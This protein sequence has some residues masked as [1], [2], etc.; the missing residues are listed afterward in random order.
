MSGSSVYTDQTRSL[1]GADS[2]GPDVVS[3]PPL[4][5]DRYALNAPIGSG[6][7]GVVW[8]ARDLRTGQAVAIKMLRP[9][10][11]DTPGAR[12][13]FHREVTNA[14][15]LDHPNIVRI[16]GHGQTANGSLYLV[17][18]RLSG[19][20]LSAHLARGAPLALTRGFHIVAQVL[21]AIGAAHRL[22]IVH[23]DLK[24]GNIILVDAADGREIVKICDF[25]LAKVIDPNASDDAEAS[26]A[27]LRSSE[28]ITT[29][30]G[31]LC[32]TPEFMAPEQ[33]R[34]EPL[35]GRAD[36]YSIAV[37]L[38][39]VV[40]G[41]LPFKGRTPFA[42]VSQHLGAAPPRPST[43]RPAAGITPALEN[44]IL[45][46]LAKDRRERPSSAEVFR[47]DLLQIEADLQRDERRRAERRPG[48][49]DASTLTA[50]PL[51]RGS[52][53]RGKSLLLGAAAV[54]AGAAAV[55]AVRSDGGSK[56][57]ASPRGPV[58]VEPQRDRATTRLVV[59]AREPVVPAVP[60][61]IIRPAP[62][63]MP[64]PMPT[65]TPTPTPT[66]QRKGRAT[67]PAASAPLPAAPTVA[68]PEAPAPTPPPLGGDTGVALRRAQD[69]MAEGQIARAC[70]LVEEAARIAPEAAPLHGFLGRCYL[71]IGRVE[72]GRASY[73]RYLE[74]APAAPDAPF[75][76][77]IVAGRR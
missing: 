1:A 5:D 3:A 56:A 15:A 74:L 6:S 20:T 55:V 34:G 39:Q 27:P 53:L 18:E 43:I 65:S 17:M 58:V 13:R 67:S 19:Q 40:T 36:L 12:S 45:R 47:A 46:G 64:M 30:Q 70:A 25:G 44:L 42:V 57:G 38:F 10:L 9:G 61:E 29:G 51:R 37:I 60:S 75:V 2:G 48:S 59:P 31:D 50:A 71:R 26:P 11:L 7:T 21:E 16:L 32:G 63:P 14:Q 72:E 76:R 33:A 77:A 41:D 24:P 35:D 52:T 23:R 8:D 49:S 73:R 22:N 69:L 54:V 68:A 28:S 62:M 66:R 4:I